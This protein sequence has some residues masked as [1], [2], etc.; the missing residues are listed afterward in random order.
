MAVERVLARESVGRLESVETYQGF[1]DRANAI[2]DS[3]LVFLIAR[4]RAG[5]SVAAYGAAAKGST[6]LNYAGVK[7]DLLPYVCDGAPS[8]QGKFLPG[9]R[10][11]IVAP[12]LLRERRPDYLLLLP[13]N[14]ADELVEQCGYI[15]EWG[16][17]FV[18]AVP[19]LR[20]SEN[21]KWVPLP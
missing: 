15:R 2:K 5:E 21:G 14:L 9:S 3:L 1:Q 10:I 17:R 12:A 7:P 8:K 11:P 13:W 19:T 18:I 4:K 20:V 6:L 16:G